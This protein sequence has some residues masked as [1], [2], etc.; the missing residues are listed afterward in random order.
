MSEN[1]QESLLDGMD[2]PKLPGSLN[3]LTILTYIGCG[4]GLLSGVWSYTG[5]KGNLERTEQMI[6]NGDID[7]LPS[8]MQGMFSP[9]M[10]EMQ[11]KAYENRLAILVISVLGYLLCFYGA[12]Q[13]RKLKKDGYFIWL[14]GEVFPIIATGVIL[15]FG[16][17]SG[18]VMIFS[19]V[20][21][22]L[23]IILY[24]VNR[25]HLKY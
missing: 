4:I 11:R 2:Q 23:F 5:A 12:M 16:F 24:T 14:V 9:E 8:F 7:K 6:N 21:V 20:I 1:A 3:V 15:G 22:L 18:G 19:M 25:K 10:I 17:L 13:M